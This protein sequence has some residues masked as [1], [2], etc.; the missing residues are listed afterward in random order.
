MVL[1]TKKI[2]I[3]EGIHPST[4]I[5]LNDEYFQKLP[6]FKTH[7]ASCL[8]KEYPIFFATQRINQHGPIITDKKM[9]VTSLQP[10]G[11]YCTEKYRTEVEEEPVFYRYDNVLGEIPILRIHKDENFFDISNTFSSVS[12][13]FKEVYE[14]LNLH[15]TGGVELKY[16][17]APESIFAGKEFSILGNLIK[18]N[19]SNIEYHHLKTWGGERIVSG[20]NK[21]YSYVD[22]TPRLEID[23]FI[24]PDRILS[25]IILREELF[26]I[27]PY[28][29]D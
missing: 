20:V 23:R 14:N 16:E 4:L 2:A 3:P 11:F 7:V 10:N 18:V 12:L 15:N 6:A 22:L 29:E 24:A 5:T 1:Y 25:E 13:Q 26:V 28:D 9:F 17:Y 27:N 19:R 21:P 8:G